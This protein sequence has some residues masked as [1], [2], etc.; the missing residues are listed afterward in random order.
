[1]KCYICNKAKK[2]TDAVA[3]CIVCGIAVCVEHQVREQYRLK[4]RTNGGSGKKR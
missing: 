2:E 3:I 4:R 1:M